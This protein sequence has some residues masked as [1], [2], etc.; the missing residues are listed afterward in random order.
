MATAPVQV[1]FDFLNASRIL[2][3]PAPQNPGDAANREYVDNKF[4][5]LSFKDNVFVGVGTNVNI[6][7]PGGTLDGQTMTTANPRVLLFAQTAGA[8]NGIYNWNGASTP[9]TRVD[10]ANAMD[11]L[12]NAVVTV[13]VGSVAGVRYRQTVMTGTL[14]TTP[15]TWVVD[16]SAIP[17]AT[18]TQSGQARLA[19]QAEVDAATANVVMTGETAFN[20]SWRVKKAFATI[21]DGSALVWTLTHNFGTRRVTIDEYSLSGNFD[22]SIVAKYRPTINTVQVVYNVPPALNSREV[23]VIG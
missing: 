5:A 2:N 15:L 7:S 18:T 8:E 22:S 11:E 13:D 9:M 20:A 4:G 12:R 23:I 19:T 16:T 3:L 21:G 17:N 6:A 1:D 10:D 14:G